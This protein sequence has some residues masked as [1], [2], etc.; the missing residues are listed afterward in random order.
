[1]ARAGQAWEEYQNRRRLNVTLSK[2]DKSL[3]F[4]SF[5]KN[6][7]FGI[8]MHYRKLYNKLEND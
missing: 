7:G 4:D 2:N 8:W 1:M 3:Q 6:L 5:K